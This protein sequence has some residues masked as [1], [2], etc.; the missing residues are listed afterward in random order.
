MFTVTLFATNTVP[1]IGVATVDVTVINN[2]PSAVISASPTSGPAP[3]TVVF[4]AV[5]SSDI[6]TPDAAELIY[7]W[8]FDDGWGFAGGLD[9]QP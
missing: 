8:N 5:G 9:H 2:S 4:S 7:Q 1:Q 6:E 3:L